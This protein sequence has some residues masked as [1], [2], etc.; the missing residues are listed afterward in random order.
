MLDTSVTQLMTTIKRGLKAR[1]KTYRD[2]AAALRLSEPTVKRMFSQGNLTVARLAELAGLLDLSLAELTR[3]AEES[4][5]PLERLTQE[6]ERELVGNTCLLLVAICALNHWSLANILDKYRLGEAECLTHLLALEKMRLISLLPGN[7]IRL[8]VARHFEWLPDG[9][10]RR[11]F[12]TQGLGDFMDSLF[13]QSAEQLVFVHGMLSEQA[14]AQLQGK[15]AR[16]HREF[17]ELHEESLKQPFAQR[18]GT[19][20][21]LA[22]R[23]WEPQAFASLRKTQ[24]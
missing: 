24:R 10:I 8:R 21:L 19:G 11:Y 1:G 22:Y 5:L 23:D 3:Q 15:L 18:R 17:A 14:Y 7:R 6:Q 12:Q 16:L 20:L 4:Q 13:D 9:P 2:V